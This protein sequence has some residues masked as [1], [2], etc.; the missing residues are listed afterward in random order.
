MGTQTLGID[1][2]NSHIA[3]VV[4]EQQ[5]R[6]PVLVNW[7]CLPMPA[8]SDPAVAIL[9]LCDQLAWKGGFCL[10]GLPLSLLSVRNLSLPFTDS[11]KI[12]QILQFELEEQLPVPVDTVVYDACRSRGEDGSTHLVVFAAGQQWLGHLLDGIRERLDPDRVLPA[13]VP[14]AEQVARR[15]PEQGP[16]L[17]VHA[18]LHSTS[19]ALVIGG[20]P[21]LYRRLSHPEQMLIHPPFSLEDGHVVADRPVAEECVRLIVHLIKQSLDFFFM[22]NRTGGPPERV[23]LTGPLAGM[24]DALVETMAASLQLPLERLHLL[25]LSGVLHTEE[26]AARWNSTRMDRALAVALAGKERR[27][28]NLRQQ[29]LAKPISLLAARRRLLLPAAAVGCLLAVGLGYLG[30]D[31]SAL[32]Q[33]D[34]ALQQE[35]AAI[36]TSTFPG[37]TKVR[38]PYVEMQAKLKA[39]QGT[40]TTMP[41][42]VTGTWVLPVL[43]DIS[44][45]IPAS[46][47]VRVARLSMDRQ[48]L[49]IK[50]TTDTF[51]GVEVIKTALS[52]SPHLSAVRIVSATANTSKKDGGKKDDGKKDDAVRFELHMQLEE[53]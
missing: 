25:E 21:V 10:C 47:A 38:D 45:R 33:R 18:D 6:T 49:V 24:D 17:L 16:F 2:S 29:H 35:M 44:R 43:A 34:Q 31:T 15:T 30:L 13:M 27:G 52:D 36:F 28:L 50:G 26:Q 42:F 7:C 51:N 1:I 5:R 23:V 22:D 19:M 39:L 40:E 46:L 11:K 12:A 37:V 53:R 48:G 3:G 14:L 8:G 41:C 9:H 32:R 4:L 20:S